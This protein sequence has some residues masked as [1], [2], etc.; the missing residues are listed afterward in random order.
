MVFGSC[1]HGNIFVV[2]CNVGV[3]PHNPHI[4]SHGGAWTVSCPI[5]EI[6]NIFWGNGSI[7]SEDQQRDF[8]SRNGWNFAGYVPDSNDEVGVFYKF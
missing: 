7:Y 2:H 4:L 1:S 5:S 3:F 8:M 6:E